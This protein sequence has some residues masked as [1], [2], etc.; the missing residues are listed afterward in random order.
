[1]TLARGVTG[2]YSPVQETGIL[3]PRQRLYAWLAFVALAAHSPVTAIFLPDDSWMLSVTVAALVAFVIVIDD[4][5]R[6][7]LRRSAPSGAEP[8]SEP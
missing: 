6:Y 8:G 7:P 3:R 2:H 4:L 5:K 1:M